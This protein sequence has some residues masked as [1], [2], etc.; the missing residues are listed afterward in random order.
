MSSAPQ[1]VTWRVLADDGEREPRRNLAHDE[2]LGR[3]AG[4][5][6]TLRLWRNDWCVALGRFRRS[7]RRSIRVP[8]GSSPCRYIDGSAGRDRRNVKGGM[9]G[10]KR[11]S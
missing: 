1:D 6:S 8:V 4:S 9:R 11:Q 7:P 10:R 2:A 3:G 5:R